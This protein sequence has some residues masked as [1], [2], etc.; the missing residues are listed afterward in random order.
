MSSGL[1]S[2]NRV[3]DNERDYGAALPFDCLQSPTEPYRALRLAS[4]QSIPG[5]CRI[6]PSMFVCYRWR[7]N[8][9]NEMRQD[10]DGV[11]LQS[12]LGTTNAR[13]LSRLGSW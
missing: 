9:E 10:G 8:V 1:R 12:S 6:R 11:V 3:T 2:V 7:D 5:I 13:R 4:L